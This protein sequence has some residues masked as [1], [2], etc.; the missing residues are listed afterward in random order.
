MYLAEYLAS[1]LPDLADDRQAL[2]HLD[3][4]GYPAVDVAEHLHIIQSLARD[5]R[6]DM[7]DEAEDMAA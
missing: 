6:A 3:A 2:E 1:T 7:A 4:A 5:M